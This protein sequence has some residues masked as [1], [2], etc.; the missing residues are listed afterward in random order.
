MRKLAPLNGIVVIALAALAGAVGVNAP[1]AEAARQAPAGS[2][3][4]PRLPDPLQ[5]GKAALARSDF[6]DAKA[7]F[8]QYL[9]ED[10]NNPEALLGEGN[11]EL[12]LKNYDAAKARYQQGIAV[13]PT[14]WAAH[15][16]MLIVYAALGDWKA[17]D[18]ERAAIATARAAHAPG[19]PPEMGFTID[20]LEVNGKRFIV[21]EFD[22]PLGTFHVRYSFV[23][24]GPDHKPQTWLSCESD[25]AD[26]AA[27]AKAHPKEAAEGKRSYSLDG[28][29]AVT[30][31]ADGKREQTRA[32]LKLYPDAEPRYETVREDVLS[33]LH[34]NPAP[35]SSTT[36]ERQ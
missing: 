13:K 32:T 16:N 8:T 4:T 10:P 28:Y 27:F 21:R 6:A 19:L 25:D 30:T 34:G 23:H 20:L 14:L 26:Q 15:E 24:F 1:T 17:F 22:P 18:T 3:G 31:T 35:L 2:L 29:S 7:F 9:E 11:A 5:V 33:I 36:S 12:G